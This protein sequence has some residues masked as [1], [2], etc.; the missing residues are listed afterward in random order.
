MILENK[1]GRCKVRQNVD[2]KLYSLNYNQISSIQVDPI[3]KKPIMKWMPGSKILSIGSYGCNFHCGFCQNHSISLEMPETIQISPEEIVGKALSLGLPSIAYTYNE[4][5]VFYEM[6]LETAQLAH[7]KGI[8][9][10]IVT[11]GFIHQEPLREILPFIDAMNIDLKA[12]DDDAYS[13]LGG[14]TV[15]NVI[16]TIKLASRYCHVEVTILIVPQMN[17][18]PN[19]FEQLLIRL[20]K[21]APN[22][23]LHLS[24]YFPRYQYDEPATDIKLMLEFK[25]IAQRYF[26]DVYLGNVR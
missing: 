19:Q 8:K 20:H 16:E 10:V 13:K 14:K 2:G 5:T 25:E 6:M 17:D 24:R 15:E 3:E 22:I 9:N 12:N 26:N 23:V 11:N 4:P 21:A 7:E 1:V 18:D